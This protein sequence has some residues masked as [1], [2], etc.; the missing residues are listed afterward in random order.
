MAQRRRRNTSRPPPPRQQACPDLA[1]YIAESDDT[2]AHAAFRIGMSQA[3]FS[4]V[5]NG[6][7]VPRAALAAR[8]SAY[9]GVPVE[10]FQRVYLARRFGRKVVA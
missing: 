1:T 2:Q 8:I 6:I 7:A 9:T 4:R 5:K 10:S 3:H